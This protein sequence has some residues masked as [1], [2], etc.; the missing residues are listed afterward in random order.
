MAVRFFNMAVIR[1]V[2][3]VA[4][5][6]ISVSTSVAQNLFA[7][8][9]RVNDSVVTNFEFDQRL[10]FL[11]L[12]NQPGDQEEIAINGLIDDRLRLQAAENLGIEPSEE[13]VLAGMEEFASR[14]ELTS[15][16]FIRAIAQ[17]GIEPESFRDFVRAGVA[18]RHVVR[19]RFAGR[20][21]ITES[22]VDRAMALSSGQGGV[23]VLLSEIILPAPPERA[24]AA[25]ELANRISRMTT[26]PEFAAAAR[27]HSASGSRGRSGRLDWVPIG[28]LPPAVRSQVLVLAPGQV[29]TPIEFPNGIALFQMRAIEETDA[30]EEDVLSVEYARYLIPGGRSESALSTARKVRDDVDTC[31]DLYGIAHGQP[32]ERLTRDTVPINEVPQ[33][34]ALEIAKLDD[35]ESS[36]N[37]TTADGQSLVFLML[38]GRVT[39]VAENLSR[40]EVREQLFQRRVASYADS[41]LAELRADATI[42][43]P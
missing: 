31:D 39:A 30:P 33:D 25:R 10:K 23:R 17:G 29:T 22:E 3:I 5:L 18:W 8:A 21:Q 11:R 42:I 4:M 40:D 37:L 24:E 34:I 13:E 36:T 19:A 43:Y 35:N 20:V 16:E 41:L 28:Q 12:L 15:E 27:R 6:G 2:S 1:V 26:L 38:C 7:P 14:A 32:E 9:V